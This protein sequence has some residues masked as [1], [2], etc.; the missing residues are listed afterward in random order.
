MEKIRIRDLGWKTVGSGIRD[1]PS[2]IRNT[3]H[4]KLNYLHTCKLPC[5]TLCLKRK[6]TYRARKG[7][8]ITKFAVAALQDGWVLDQATSNCVVLIFCGYLS[9]IPL[10]VFVHCTNTVSNVQYR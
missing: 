7:A 4:Y 2:R 6:T 1:K 8:E 10:T 5:R 9:Y 3:D